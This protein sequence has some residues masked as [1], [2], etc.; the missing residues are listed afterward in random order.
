MNNQSNFSQQPFKP[1]GQLKT[2]RGLLKF[3]L[4]NLITFGIYSIVIFSSVSNDIN[5]ICSRYDGKKTMHYCLLLFIIGPLTLGIAYIVWFHKL[6]ERIGSELNRRN[7]AYSFSATDFWLWD[8][9]GSL[10]IVGPFV[11]IHKLFKA[12][13]LLSESYNTYG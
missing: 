10:I 11:Y 7:I 6:S 13:N 4:L 12:M 9:L 3:I 1:V 2:S 5:V 8:V